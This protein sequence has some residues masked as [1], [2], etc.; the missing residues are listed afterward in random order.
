VIVLFM[1]L[2][3]TSVAH[4]FLR[5]K[6]QPAAWLANPQNEDTF[7]LLRTINILP[8]IAA[9]GSVAL[10]APPA[11]AAEASR[12]TGNVA[13]WVGHAAAVGEA[14]DAQRVSVVVHM[15]LQHADDLKQVADSVSRPGSE[16]YG[17]Y[18]SAATFRSTFAPAA[19]DVAAVQAM[20]ADAGM[21]D[22]SVGAAGATVSATA[23]V[24]Q[25]RTTFH[26]T[27]Q[28]YRTGATTMRANGEEPTIPAALAGKVVY[29]E[30]LD[31]TTFLKQPQHVSAIAGALVAPA[32][33]GL[34]SPGGAAPGA[35]GSDQAAA[36][37]P[38][39]VTP[40]P[41]AASLPS[42]FC[43]T[44]FGDLKATLST[45]PGAYKKTMPWLVCGYTPQQVRA[46]YGFD[47]VKLDGTGVTVAIIDAYASPTLMADGNRYA[48]NHGL[49]PLTADNFTQIIPKG[50]YN[51]SASE[52]CGPYGWWGE[53][54][55][56]LA[57]VHGSAPGASIVY[58]G[59]RDCGTSLTVAL[60]NTIYNQQAD[61]IT[62]SYGFNSEAVSAAD[63]A[64]EDQ[65]FM[66]A[67][68]MGITVLFSSGDSGDL[69]QINGVATGSW[70]ATSPYVTGV[71]G[72]SLAVTD[73]AGAKAEYGWGTYR[74]NLADATVN[75]GTSITTSGLAQT[76]VAGTTYDAFSFYAGAG[77]GI[78]LIEPQPSYQVPVVPAALATTLNQ[79][80]GS[81]V[82][83]AARRVSPD[84]SMVADPYTGYLY[85]ETYTIAGDPGSDSG[86]TAI[87]DTTEYCEGAIGGTSLSSPLMA[88]AVALMNQARLA[89]GKAVVGFANPLFYSTRIGTGAAYK[90]SA[91]NQILP[92][93]TPVSLLRGYANDLTRVRVVTVNSVSTL[94]ETTPFPLVVCSLPICE[95]LNDVFNVVTPGY[96]D[97]TGL[98]VPYLPALV[99]Q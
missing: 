4:L 71:G 60:L 13:Q 18:I 89:R 20:L 28:L 23:T 39:G 98:G 96:N 34:A 88:G 30:G 43:D 33:A 47:K 36:A 66:A 61:I 8:E 70:E 37:K 63:V 84:V 40:P 9:I 64:M 21:S 24:A 1:Q 6:A 73:A 54:S 46:A 59:A 25:L 75:G 67:A 55:L 81:A 3:G 44:Y 99:K 57:A 7:L 92:P 93:A 29:I 41:V 80:N 16:S 26:V 17:H 95:G 65:A 76:T 85:G 19:A 50:I 5:H 56:D 14:P 69:S 62:N 15:R 31:D 78:S 87:S 49:P 82:T 58:V 35:L 86:C 38:P 74:A 94:A 53:E 12:V 90:A 45:K 11:G 22:I 42:P 79:G 32:G 2:Y 83:L 27:Q 48:A 97:V 91:F 51:V 72:T 77:G 68:A 10:A 52:A